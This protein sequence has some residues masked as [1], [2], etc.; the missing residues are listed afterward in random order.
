MEEMHRPGPGE[1]AW[2]PLPSLSRVPPHKRPSG[3]PPGR[4]SVLLG[5]Q[6]GFDYMGMTDC[7]TGH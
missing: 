1:G 3:H 7:I 2:A 4:S 5:F 6:G